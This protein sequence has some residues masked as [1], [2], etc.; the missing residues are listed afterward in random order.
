MVCLMKFLLG[1]SNS[2]Y[3]KSSPVNPLTGEKL[4]HKETVNSHPNFLWIGVV[5]DKMIL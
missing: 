2:L 3:N 5:K 1:M 4:S